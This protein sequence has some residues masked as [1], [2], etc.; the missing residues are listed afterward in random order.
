MDIEQ[1]LEHLVRNEV[2][3]N[4]SYL[5]ATLAQGYGAIGMDKDA[6]G[7]SVL[8]EQAFDLASPVPDYEEALIRSGW[9]ETPEGWWWR[10]PD[11]GEAADFYFLGSGPFIRS[12]EMAKTICQQ[13]G[14]DP[15]EW[16]VYEHSIVSKWLAE[17]LAELGEK[18][19]TDFAG[20][21]VWARTTTGQAISADGI[22]RRVLD[23]IDKRV[24]EVA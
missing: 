4:C 1:R 10:E 20:L 6:M 13:E 11:E 21:C 15:Y 23:L 18:V 9:T 8:M 16:E 7:L 14:I 17:A 3:S 5:V 24:K 12:D 19:D 22:M 2:L